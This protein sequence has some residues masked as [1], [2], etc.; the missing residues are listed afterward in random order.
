MNEKLVSVLAEVFNLQPDQINPDLT[1]EDV[2]NWDSL[3]QLDL[4]MSLERVYSIS[5]VIED[6]VRLDSVAKIIEVLKMKGVDF[7]D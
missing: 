7:G 4:V 1:K 2:G 6:I 5:L 3:K